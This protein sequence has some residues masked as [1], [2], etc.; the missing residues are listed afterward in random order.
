MAVDSEAILLLERFATQNFQKKKIRTY[1]QI[2]PFKLI[3]LRLYNR[4]Y[5]R[6]PFWFCVEREPVI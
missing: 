4:G 2:G 1:I 3:L 5:A 6:P